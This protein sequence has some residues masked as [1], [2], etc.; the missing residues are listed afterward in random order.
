[1]RAFDSF[2][3]LFFFFFA[4]VQSHIPW[5]RCVDRVDSDPDIRKGAKVGA[6]GE[7]FHG[8]RSTVATGRNE[9]KIL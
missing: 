8:V 6:A 2:S 1:M 3:F 7:E 4:P 9:S 5:D